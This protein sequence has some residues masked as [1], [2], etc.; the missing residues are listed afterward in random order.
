MGSSKG[1]V[2]C[3]QKLREISVEEMFISVSAVK[4]W[5]WQSKAIERKWQERNQAVKRGLHA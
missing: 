3:C 2:N 5:R 4:F 1:A